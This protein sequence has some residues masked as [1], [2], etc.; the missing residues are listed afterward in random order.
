MTKTMT[1]AI[2]HF[3]VAFSVAYLLTGSL[4]IGGA[5]AL[6][7]PAVNT[8]AFHFHEKLWKHLEQSDSNSFVE[9]I[10]STKDDSKMDSM[11][12]E[13]HCNIHCNY[14]NALKDTASEGST[15]MMV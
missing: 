14:N 15:K 12:L 2:L 13:H 6:I 7:E 11:L 1:F 8:V 4:A 10:F 9:K 5:V 3:A